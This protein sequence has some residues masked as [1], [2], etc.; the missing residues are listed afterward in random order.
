MFM[1]VN[2]GQFSPKAQ[3]TR[4]EIALLTNNFVHSERFEQYKESIGILLE[5]GKKVS[6]SDS[7]F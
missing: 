2:D 1:Q 4:Q 7:T 5:T 3:V 6:N